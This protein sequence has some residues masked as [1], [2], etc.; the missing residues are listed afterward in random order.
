MANKNE[1]PPMT[2]KTW[3]KESDEPYDKKI[4]VKKFQTRVKANKDIQNIEQLWVDTFLQPVMSFFG[5]EDVWTKL[6]PNVE[7]YGVNKKMGSRK[8]NITGRPQAH[9]SST[10]WT[11][12]RPDQKNWFNPYDKYQIN[13]TN[14]FC[15]TFALMNLC[16][17]LP[18]DAPRSE[19][20][21]WTKYYYYTEKALEFMQETVKKHFPK[22]KKI[23][24]KIKECKKHSNRCIN[25]I[26]FLPFS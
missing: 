24:E 8:I 18:P 9:F 2:E 19:Y 17:K 3:N 1:Q 6:V 4:K 22:N 25:C 15:Q 20:N 7:M 26:E 10:H 12:R 16:D 14:Q 11:S 23:L 21:S 5:E 13:G